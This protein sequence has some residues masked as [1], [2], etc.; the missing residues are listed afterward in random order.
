[1]QYD[2]TGTIQMA[3][4]IHRRFGL[5]IRQA[6]ICHHHVSALKNR[7]VLPFLHRREAPHYRNRNKWQYLDEVFSTFR[8]HSLRLKVS[9]WSTLFPTAACHGWGVL[10]G[11]L[12]SCS[13]EWCSP[14]RDSPVQ[15]LFASLR[16]THF[17]TKSLSYHGPSH[18]S[19]PAL[20]SKQWMRKRGCYCNIFPP[21]EISDL[22]TPATRFCM[23]IKTSQF[24]CAKSEDPFCII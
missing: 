9:V 12:L 6:L 10:L 5:A 24:R 13:A 7:T 22:I 17:Y 14:E 8:V 19:E 21:A 16:A 23:C 11:G 20:A 2:K 1:M 4:L 3:Q 18:T 15:N